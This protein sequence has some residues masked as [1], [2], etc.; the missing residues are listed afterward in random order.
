MISMVVSQSIKV[1]SLLKLVSE[2]PRS[3]RS[4]VL[5]TLPEHGPWASTLLESGPIDPA[6][7]EPDSITR[8]YPEDGNPWATTPRF[9]VLRL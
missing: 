4:S 7:H 3:G 2:S 1:T 9:C 6:L 5:A 8:G